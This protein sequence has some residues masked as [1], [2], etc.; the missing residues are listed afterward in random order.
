MKIKHN[1][2]TRTGPQR[3]IITSQ[4]GA[5]THQWAKQIGAQLKRQTGI[6]AAVYHVGDMMYQAD[7]TIPPGRILFLP[8]E[9]LGHLRT[10]V[11]ERIHLDMIQ[12]PKRHAIVVSHACFKWNHDLF[13]GLRNQELKGFAPH[14][15]LFLNTDIDQVYH[16]M[17][18]KHPDLHFSFHHL[19]NWRQEEIVLGETM[20]EGLGL[21]HRYFLI[22]YGEPERSVMSACRIILSEDPSGI[23]TA[24]P[25]T[26]VQK[27]PRLMR[28][29]ERYRAWMSGRALCFDPND[30]EYG[31]IV[32]AREAE[33]AGKRTFKHV[34][35]G[36]QVVFDTAEIVASGHRV[37]SQLIARDFRLIAQSKAIVALVPTDDDGKPVLSSGVTMET[38]RALST[39]REVFVIWTPRVEPS[40]FMSLPNLTERVRSFGEL[41]GVLGRHGYLD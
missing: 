22:N 20:A 23:Y 4:P 39:G 7:R 18:T 27:H 2:Q 41:N 34:I 37:E 16:R 26:F 31:L 29:I 40:P 35:D 3:V 10:I 12:N 33:R 28:E 36:E 25:I 19:L 15:W 21:S 8:P 17:R 30:I 13:T 5:R 32:S 9:Q 6:P 24:F 11:F 38:L 14:T 1:K